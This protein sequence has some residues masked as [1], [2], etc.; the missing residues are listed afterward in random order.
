MIKVLEQAV[1]K[2]RGL[3]RE[4]QEAAAQ[5]LRVIA[6]QSYGKLTPREIAGVRQAQREARKGKLAS[7]RKVKAF[8]A[9][10]RS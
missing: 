4:R 2:V 10:F 8:F 7:D 3:P 6:A 9:R 1:D 5:V